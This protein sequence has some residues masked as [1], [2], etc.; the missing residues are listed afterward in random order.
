M[1][2]KLQSA[3]AIATEKLEK[4]LVNT[5]FENQIELA[6]GNNIEVNAAKELI[7]NLIARKNV[8]AIETLSAD[9]IDGANGAFAAENNTIY[10]AQEYL[11]KSNLEEISALLLEEWGHYLD[12]QSNV[13]DSP[14][15]E[16]AIFSALVRGESLSDNELSLLRNEN[17][18]SIALLD[19]KKILIEQN[20]FSNIEIRFKT[21]IPSDAVSIT[22]KEIAEIVSLFSIFGG[23][24]RGFSYGS[25]DYRSLQN[26]VINIDPNNISPIVGEFERDWGETKEYDSD[27][28]FRVSSKPF[29]WWEIKENEIPLDKE[30]L[31]VTGDNNL[32][33]VFR[34]D[35]NTVK[36]SFELEGGNPL[37]P[38]PQFLAPTISAD[39]DV[40]VRKINDE[41]FYRIEGEHDGFPA[42]ELYIDEKRVY[43][44]DPEARNQTPFSLAIDREWEIDTNWEN[45][46][47]NSETNIDYDE[48]EITRLL[49]FGTENPNPSDYNEH[50][51]SND[52]PQPSITLSMSD[53]MNKGAG[54][55]AYPSL[56][57]V[58]EEFFEAE[59]LP[60]NAS[61]NINALQEQ[62]GTTFEEEDFRL[63]ISQYGT[64]IFSSDHPERSYL[65]GSGL[66]RL[67]SS[68]T[69]FNVLNGVKTIEN[70]EVRAFDENF[71]FEAGSVLANIVNSVL[72]ESLDPYELSR[73]ELNIEFDGSGAIYENY[74][75]ADF[76]ADR[77][78]EGTV[79]VIGTITRDLEDAAGISRL[80]TTGVSYFLNIASDPFLSY[81]NDNKTVI[82]GTPENDDLNSSDE[83]VLI[84]GTE[85]Y[86]IVGGN[87]NDTLNGDD[88]NDELRGGDGNDNL[89]GDNGN[90][91][92]FGEEGN[93]NLNGD[94]GNDIFDAGEDNDFLDGGNDIDVAL[95]SDRI[96]NYDYTIIE[97]G[98]IAFTHTRGTQVDGNDN[99][100][101]IEFAIFTDRNIF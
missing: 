28:G 48:I 72:G 30:T 1:L 45:L 96:E 53:Y 89:N 4:F 66:F 22:S 78:I 20:S 37:A 13:K 7:Q 61:Y 80:T 90:D 81:V 2:L 88:N 52:A 57:N 85:G 59:N 11:E 14:G 63:G 68:N 69:S 73:E 58:V 62:L 32:I 39:F 3:N 44:H 8:P 49:V 87:G 65:F 34:E 84:E 86:F 98:S 18:T 71:D 95:F 26:V 83:E 36:V 12:W 25:E 74:S 82:Y 97:D 41:L 16:G 101:N 9:K 76:N 38:E 29:W 100:K 60:N 50:I 31:L 46:D 33:S 15:D 6:F 94:N 77:N 56:F 91:F 67:D 40:F 21:F 43:E 79:S 70:M 17:D 47:F 99:L 93:D 23:D 92:L 64:D 51:R 55:Y 75:E 35:S 54:R 5:D 42:Y 24:D 10:L 19:E 27:Q